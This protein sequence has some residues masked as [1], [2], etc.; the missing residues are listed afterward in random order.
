[1]KKPKQRSR[2]DGMTGQVN[3]KTPKAAAPAVI[4][5]N[6]HK[7]GARGSKGCGKRGKGR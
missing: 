4:G 5:V 2:I 7:G 6:V 1:M 3:A